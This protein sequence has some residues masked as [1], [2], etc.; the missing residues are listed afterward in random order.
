MPKWH[1]QI[2]F[3]VTTACCLTTLL[4]TWKFKG[5][6]GEDRLMDIAKAAGISYFTTLAGAIV[7]FIV[8]PQG[9]HA[10]RWF[11]FSLFWSSVAVLWFGWEAA[12]LSDKMDPDKYM[13]AVVYFYA[14]IVAVIACLIMCCL[15]CGAGGDAGGAEPPSSS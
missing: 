3:F 8:F 5:E 4:S 14:D 11:V 13:L 12:K 2:G 9:E 15:L 7:F 6:T 1:Y 10:A